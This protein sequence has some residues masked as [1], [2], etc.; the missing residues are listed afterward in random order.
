MPKKY[1]NEGS[2]LFKIEIDT[3]LN[4][5]EEANEELLSKANKLFQEV[6]VLT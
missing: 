5:I 3:V 1:T 4:R 6:E 2:N